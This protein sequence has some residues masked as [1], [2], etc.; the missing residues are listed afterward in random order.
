MARKEQFSSQWGLVASALGMAIG[1]GN[2]WRF[3]RIAAK[4]G[5]G[6]F[7]IPWMLALLLWSIPLLMAESAIGKATRRGTVG[8]FASLVGRRG[9]WMGGFVALCTVAIM[10]YYSVVTGWCLR[11]LAA[12][13][14]GGLTGV[15]TRLYWENF[16]AHRWET[17]LFHLGAMAIAVAVLHGGVA[18]G[19]ERVNKVLIPSLFV[20][21]AIAAVRA[22]TLP[23]AVGGLEFFFRPKWSTLAHYRV[24]L[25]GLT[26]SAWSTG[27]GWGLFLTY[28][29]YSRKREDVPLNSLVVGF[30]N[31]SASLLVGMGLFP[32]VFALAPGLGLEPGDVLR[33]SG[34]ASTGMAF[35]WVP[36]LFAV[37]PGGRWL[38]VVFFLA[39]SMAAITSLM[40]M[41]ELATCN[42]VDAGMTRRTAVS[43]AA[44][45]GFLAGLPSAFRLSFLENQDWAWGLGLLLCGFFF[46]IAVNRYGVRRFREELINAPGASMRVGRWWELLLRF[47]IPAEFLALVAWWFY[48]AIVVFEPHSWWNPLRTFSLGTCLAQW[49]AGIG[50]LLCANRFLARRFLSAGSRT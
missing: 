5:G 11:Y 1:T 12:A 35:L 18:R 7:L 19:I 32:A 43:V 30:G 47:V 28:A 37:C 6:A 26:Q 20:L 50:A 15:D 13:L 44:G 27:A 31:N 9:A 49:G 14:G 42:L 23:G 38:M 17:S 2:I 29:V 24:W 21:L 25:E 16:I 10:C 41:L 48:Q 46:T 3:P 8:A 45:F 34:P 40:S 33:E 36:R 39:L 22:L 4:N